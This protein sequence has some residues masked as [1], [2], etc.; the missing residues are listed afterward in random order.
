MKIKLKTKKSLI[1][2]IK[3]T[4]SG[5]IKVG[6]AYTSHLAATKSKKQKRHLSKQN[7]MNQ[8]D[9]KRLKGLY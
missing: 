8:T 1:K 3:L 7:I 4:S 2:R 6:H 5:Q 9:V